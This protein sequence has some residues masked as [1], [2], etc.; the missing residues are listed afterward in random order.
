MRSFVVLVSLL[1]AP[2][3]AFAAT[4][5]SAASVD[6]PRRKSGL[7]E[8][9]AS[10]SQMKGGHTMQQC[11]DQKSDD[12]MKKDMQGMEKTSCTKNEMRK[13]GD[14]IVSE[15]V[16]KINGSTATTR[17]VFSGR[18]DSAYKADIKSTYEPPMRGMRE[19]STVIEAKWLG[20][21]KPGQKPGDISMPGMP[22]GIN[23]EELMKKMP[24]TQ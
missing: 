22:E 16:C 15:S 17:A 21:C 20:A 5:V 7:W 14:R 1:V 24:K 3:I 12:L 18:F 11:I 4:P 6:A 10:S 13:E 9:T 19:S 8:I 2:T 23:I